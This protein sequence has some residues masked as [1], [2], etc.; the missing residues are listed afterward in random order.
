LSINCEFPPELNDTQLMAYLDDEANPEIARHLEKC[1]Y[2]RKKAEAL[3]R[4]QKRLTSQLYRITCPSPTELGEYHLRTLPASQMLIVSQHLR[5]CPHCVREISQLDEFLVEL[6]PPPGLI[7]SARVL[8]AR[9]IKKPGTDQDTEGF[10]GAP[11]IAGVRG[12]EEEPFIYQTDGIQIVIDVQE[13]LEQVG[14][15]TLLGLVTGLETNEF[16]I[17]VSQG[18]QVI[19]TASVDEI[20]NFIIPHLSPGHYKLILSGPNMELHVQSLPVR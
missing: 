8:I 17:Q 5:E 18:D 10:L 14:L 19:A 13:D 20:G 4:L 12:E 16:T 15:K 3:D 7:K 9:L 2:C 6:T 1:S 11:A